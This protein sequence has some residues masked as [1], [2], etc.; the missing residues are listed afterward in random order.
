[1]PQVPPR[2]IL[3]DGDCGFCARAVQWV[4]DRDP[5]GVF[6]FAPLQGQT[7]AELRQ[8]HAELPEGL[9]TLVLVESRDGGE[10]ISLRSEALFRI[11]AQLQGSSRRLTW[12]AWLPRPLTDFAYSCFARVRHRVL[13]DQ[14]ACRVPDADERV[15]FLP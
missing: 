5:R 12:L 6:H 4:L 13:R 15:R 10:W 7:A 11:A 3:Y 2:L 1:M 14:E 9:D 8:S